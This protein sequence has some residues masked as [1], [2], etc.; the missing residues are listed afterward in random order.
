MNGSEY[1][2]DEEEKMRF[3]QLHEI[4]VVEVP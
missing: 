4:V 2:P 1:D 3:S